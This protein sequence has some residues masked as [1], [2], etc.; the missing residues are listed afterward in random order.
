MFHSITDTMDTLPQDVINHIVAYLDAAP[1]F[2]WL[3]LCSKQ[4]FSTHLGN[5]KSISQ[6][7]RAYSSLRK[8][9]EPFV[10]PKN[11]RDALSIFACHHIPSDWLRKD[12]DSWKRGLSIAGYEALPPYSLYLTHSQTEPKDRDVMSTA[13]YKDW[14]YEIEFKY[15]VR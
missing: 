13:P 1:I 14:R 2:R 11:Q 5:D 3:R 4:L 8:P 6:I 7:S 12:P 10:A 9:A 15:R